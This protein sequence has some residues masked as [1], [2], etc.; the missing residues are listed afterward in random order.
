MIITCRAAEDL[1][2]TAQFTYDNMKGYYERFAPDWDV[3]KVMEAVQPLDNREI[4]LANQVVGVMRIEFRER[5]CW[6]RDLQVIASAQNKGIGKAALEKVKEI[7]AQ[8]G[9]YAVKL[10]VFKISPAVALYN[11]NGFF[12]QSEDEKFYNMQFDLQAEK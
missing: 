1:L 2:R 12:T 7:A 10:R 9:A 11:R 8:H 3:N 4:L 5:I 6:L